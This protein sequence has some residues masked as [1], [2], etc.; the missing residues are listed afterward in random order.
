MRL[1]K[2]I[3]KRILPNTYLKCWA[4]SYYSIWLTT[5]YVRSNDSRTKVGFILTLFP[6]AIVVDI[7][8]T[9]HITQVTFEHCS[10]QLHFSLLLTK[11]VRR[12]NAGIL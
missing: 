2:K 4:K 5:E 8:S 6:K 11:Y 1:Y 12:S 3:S 7:C 10:L 9:L